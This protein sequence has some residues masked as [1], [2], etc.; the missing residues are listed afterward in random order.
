M[1]QIRR[2]NISSKTHCHKVILQNTNTDL[3]SIQE[4]KPFSLE[5]K[6]TSKLLFSKYCIITQKNHKSNRRTLLLLLPLKFD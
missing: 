1:Q 2:A 3:V 6:E 4:S 5:Q